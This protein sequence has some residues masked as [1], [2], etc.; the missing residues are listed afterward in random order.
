[1]IGALIGLVLG[2]VYGATAGS[3]N[4]I[5][6]WGIPLQVQVGAVVFGMIVVWAH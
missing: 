5:L 1:M 3:I 2:L 4:S 6:L